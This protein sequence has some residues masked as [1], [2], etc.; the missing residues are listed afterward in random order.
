[1]FVLLKSALFHLLSEKELDSAY[2][3]LRTVSGNLSNR[4]DIIG[5][6][7]RMPG[8]RKDGTASNFKMAP[9]AIVDAMGGNSDLLGF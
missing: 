5:E 7:M 9:Q 3:L 6:K 8:I 2:E 1:M 4:P